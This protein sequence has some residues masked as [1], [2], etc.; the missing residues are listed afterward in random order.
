M[1]DHWL[2]RRASVKRLCIASITLL[3]L[4]VLAQIAFPVEGHFGVDGSFAFNAWYGFAA[5]AAMILVAKLLGALPKRRDTY[6][7]D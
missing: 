4:T 7:D 2:V 6:Y 3:A 1:Q 5:C